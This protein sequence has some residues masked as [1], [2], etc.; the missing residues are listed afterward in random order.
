MRMLTL[1]LTRH[2]EM[3]SVF[4]SILCHVLLCVDIYMFSLRI[5]YATGYY[6]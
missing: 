4:A 6:D 2:F 3:L 1:P 5:F